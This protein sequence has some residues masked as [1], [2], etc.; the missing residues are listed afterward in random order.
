MYRVF[1]LIALCCG[2]SIDSPPPPQTATTQNGP[3]QTAVTFPTSF[4][5]LGVE[6]KISGNDD[7]VPEVPGFKSRLYVQDDDR[8]PWR[9]WHGV[10]TDGRTKYFEMV[11]RDTNPPWARDRMYLLYR[12]DGMIEQWKGYDNKASVG[13]PQVVS[14]N[15]VHED[16]QLT[17]FVYD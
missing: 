12:P 13:F 16:L 8:M 11:N 1:V 3:A 9:I 4:R 5:H 15:Q 2:C 17:D 6:F 7:R 14:P 10:S